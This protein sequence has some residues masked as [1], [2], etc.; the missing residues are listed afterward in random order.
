MKHK[1]RKKVRPIRLI[2]VRLKDLE[3]HCYPCW[4]CGRVFINYGFLKT[5]ERLC[6]SCRYIYWQE[7]SNKEMLK[8]RELKSNLRGWD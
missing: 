4:G 6:L 2:S 7:W 8:K 1:Q 3:K 5:S